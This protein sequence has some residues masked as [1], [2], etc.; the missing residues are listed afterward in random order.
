MDSEQQLIVELS[1]RKLAFEIYLHL[2][3]GY[4]TVDLG[5]YGRFFFR[6]Q[7]IDVLDQL[8]TIEHE[9]MG[10]QRVIVTED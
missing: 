10:N 3:Q 6:E 4:F 9:L 7:E 8:P 2:F 1:V 5:L